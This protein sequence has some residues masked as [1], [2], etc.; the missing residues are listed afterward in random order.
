MLVVLQRYLAQLPH[1]LAGARSL[2]RAGAAG[3]DGPEYRL[4]CPAANGSGGFLSGG[5]Y[6][7][8]LRRLRREYAQQVPLMAQAVLKHFPEGTRVTSPR[9]GY[10]LWV[11]LP[12]GVDSLALYTQAMAQGIGIAPGYMFSATPKYRNFIRLNA[13]FWSYSA[14]GALERLAGLVKQVTKG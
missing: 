3:E 1:G 11:Q 6:D 8:H 5:G 9:G 4:G 10:V 14:L 13:A 2:L 12:E 7:H